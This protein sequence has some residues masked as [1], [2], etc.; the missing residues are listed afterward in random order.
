LPKT[1]FSIDVIGLFPGALPCELRLGSFWQKI[2]RY[3][4]DSNSSNP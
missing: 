1:I 4:L 2:R 3:F